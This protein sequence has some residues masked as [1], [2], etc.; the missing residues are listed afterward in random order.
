M[1]ADQYP[2]RAIDSVTIG[3]VVP[4]LAIPITRTMIVATAIASRD[5]EDV[6]HDPDR[7]REKGSADIFMN[8]LTSNGLVERYVRG[9]S[10]PAAQLTALKIRL[11]APNYPGDTMLLSANV[12]AVDLGTGRVLLDVIGSNSLGT[13]LAGTAELQLGPVPRV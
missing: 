9:W 1:K 3:D 8:I 5:Y 6:H 2:S 12:T 10:G 13:H 11:G 4:E 7:A